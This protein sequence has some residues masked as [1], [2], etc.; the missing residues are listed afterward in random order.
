[1]KKNL[2]ST[3]AEAQQAAIGLGITTVTEYK[4]RS[5]EDPRLPYEPDSAY[6]KDWPTENGWPIFLEKEIKEHYPTFS[7]AQQ[8]AIALGI[9]TVRE[10]NRRYKEDPRL[11]S[12]PDRTYGK[13]W[14]LKNAWPTFLGKKEK[15]Y[16]S[17]FSEAQQ[18][19]IALG[20]TTVTEYKRRYKEDPCLPLAPHKIYTEEWP[21]ENAWPIFL[22]KEVKEYY[23]T[24]VEAQ[25]AAIALGIVSYT[26]YRLRYKENPRLPLKPNKIYAGEWPPK[27]GWAIFL[28]QE[29]KITY[30]TF[31]EAQQAAVAL[32]ITTSKEYRVRYKEDPR[33]PYDP[34]RIYAK[35]WSLKNGWPI[36]LGKEV[37]EYYP[38][39]AEAQ[40]AAIALGITTGKEYRQRY[41]EDPCLPSAPDT[42]YAGKWP[43][44][45]GWLIFLGQ[46][47]KITYPTY[48]EAQQ[49][50]IALGITTSKEYRLRYK[51]DPRLPSAPDTT[52]AGKWPPENGWLIFFGEG[53]KG[54][55]SNVHR[56]SAGCDCPGYCFS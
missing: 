44:E 51:E 9:T 31:A 27:N 4:R 37:K 41:K 11:P 32:G 5:K 16:Y 55:L 17:T 8:A 56:G 33:L 1:M 20:I 25:Q 36:F 34:D 18:A 54:I 50:A 42:T 12:A 15:E 43:P 38:T 19:T 49:A 39:F 13:D 30:P 26:Q 6:G 3:Y 10:Y 22:E 29:G 21:L 23:P 53:Y 46:E 48:I 24:F 40:Q 52:Y 45:N 35:E 2:Y 28:G 7:E 14:P 47:Y